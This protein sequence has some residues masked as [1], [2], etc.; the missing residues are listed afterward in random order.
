MKEVQGA[1]LKIVLPVVLSREKA[2]PARVLEAVPKE[3][4]VV[5]HDQKEEGIDPLQVGARKARAVP[6]EAT[7]V[8]KVV[9]GV[10]PPKEEEAVS[11]VP[12][13]PGVLSGKPRRCRSPAKLSVHGS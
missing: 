4:V 11:V 13:V 3:E 8:L 1:V 2:S 7:T 5:E 9:V 12:T 10:D 6:V